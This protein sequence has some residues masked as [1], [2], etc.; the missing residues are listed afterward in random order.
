M[1]GFMTDKMSYRL[2]N[3]IIIVFGNT[4]NLLADL[5]PFHY[6]RSTSS[7]GVCQVNN[8][9]SWLYIMTVVVIFMGCSKAF[10]L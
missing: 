10:S 8:N 1:Q 4:M 5:P 6:Q 3:I 2:S 9:I 7:N